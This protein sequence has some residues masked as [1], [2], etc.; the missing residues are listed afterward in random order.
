[1]RKREMDHE[2]MFNLYSFLRLTKIR[3]SHKFRTRDR[4]TDRLGKI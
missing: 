2:K 1:M 3:K 4:Q